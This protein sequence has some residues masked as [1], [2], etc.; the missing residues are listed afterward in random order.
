[1]EKFH[2]ETIASNYKDGFSDKPAEPLETYI[3]DVYEGPRIRIHWVKLEGPETDNWPPENYQRLLGTTK[4]GQIEQEP[5]DLIRE[6]ARR[7]FRRPV[8]NAEAELYQTFY[9]QE[10]ASGATPVSALADTYKAILTSPN[11][12]YIEAPIDEAAVEA[13]EEGLASKLR[14]YDL[15]SRLSYALWGSMHDDRTKIWIQYSPK[16]CLSEPLRQ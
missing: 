11:F 13:A 4:R 2:P 10:I 14:A 7:A 6:F 16:P 15:A 3:S 1:M 9:D 8:L 5:Y 12:L